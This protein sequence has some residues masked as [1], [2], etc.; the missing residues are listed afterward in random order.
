[1][2]KNHFARIM[3][4]VRLKLSRPK[5][6]GVV[7]QIWVATHYLRTADLEH[8]Q[9]FIETNKQSAAA[10]DNQTPRDSDDTRERNQAAGAAA[11]WLGLWLDC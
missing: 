10:Q 8:R 3:Q 6:E 1:M 11:I 2:S 7:T 4:A 5:L 9:P